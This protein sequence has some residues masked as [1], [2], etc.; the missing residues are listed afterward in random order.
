MLCDTYTLD[1]DGR[2]NAIVNRPLPQTPHLSPPF[3]KYS[4]ACASLDRSLLKKQKEAQLDKPNTFRTLPRPRKIRQI[5]LPFFNAIS[6][7]A[8]SSDVSKETARLSDHVASD[9]KKCTLTRVQK[10]LSRSVDTLTASQRVSHFYENPYLVEGAGAGGEPSGTHLEPPYSR[11]SSIPATSDENLPKDKEHFYTR[12]SQFMDGQENRLNRHSYASIHYPS[13]RSRP[14]SKHVYIDIIFGSANSVCIPSLE[15]PQTNSDPTKRAKT[16]SKSLPCLNSSNEDNNPNIKHTPRPNSYYP[17]TDTSGGLYSIDSRNV[18]TQVSNKDD[19][20]SFTDS[21]YQNIK[22]SLGIPP[23][24]NDASPSNGYQNLQESLNSSQDSENVYKTPTSLNVRPYY[25]NIT[26]VRDNTDWENQQDNGND[27]SH[28]GVPKSP[29][30]PLNRFCEIL[31]K[32]S[33]GQAMSPQGADASVPSKD[34]GNLEIWRR[35]RESADEHAKKGERETLSTYLEGR[36]NEEQFQEDE[37][38]HRTIENETCI[39]NGQNNE[40]TYENFISA[41]RDSCISEESTHDHVSLGSSLSIEDKEIYENQPLIPKTSDV[42]GNSVCEGF[43]QKLEV[44]GKSLL[45]S[46]LFGESVA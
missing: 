43:V 13:F 26:C 38:V 29:P 14:K 24:A 12:I 42:N 23:L 15:N 9:P 20:G 27:T 11:V 4:A 46:T 7:S 31:E 34:D 36:F 16:L 37:T 45:G 33:N 28:Y 2:V 19:S 40:P 3:D 25:E 6:R 21:R 39:N 35:K 1:V 8:S 17:P 32:T 22:E 10:R 44:R 30:I 41:H 5:P 18:R